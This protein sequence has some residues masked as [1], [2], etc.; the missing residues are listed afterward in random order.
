MMGHVYNFS[1]SGD[2]GQEDG[3]FKAS[4]GKIREN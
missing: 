4:L 1:Y 3:K 2:G